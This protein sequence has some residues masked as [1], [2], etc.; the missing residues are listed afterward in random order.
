MDIGAHLDVKFRG[1]RNFILKKLICWNGGGRIKVKDTCSGDDLE[2]EVVLVEDVG[3]SLGLWLCP[4]GLLFW[5]F[6]L[7]FIRF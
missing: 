5:V 2:E 4:L 3:C 7:S 6:S 1:E